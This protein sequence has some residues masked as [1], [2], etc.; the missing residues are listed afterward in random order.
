MQQPRIQGAT[1]KI[2]D[3]Q[4]GRGVRKWNKLVNDLARCCGISKCL[5]FTY[6]NSY[7]DYNSNK[8]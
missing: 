6:V 7:V 2:K 3:F 1:H 4:G 5:V 8:R